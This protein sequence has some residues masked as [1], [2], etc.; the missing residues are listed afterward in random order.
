[1]ANTIMHLN[2]SDFVFFTSYLHGG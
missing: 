2:G 1:M